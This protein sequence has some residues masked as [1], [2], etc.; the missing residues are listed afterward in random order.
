MPIVYADVLSDG[1]LVTGS[2]S[3][4][5]GHWY[6]PVGAVYYAFYANA[7]ASVTVTCRRLSGPYDPSLWVLQG[8]F[9]DTDIFGGDL[10]SLGFIAFGDDELPPNIPG[11][12]WDPQ[13]SFIAPATGYYTVAVTNFSSNGTPPYDFNLVA[14]G[15]S[16]AAIPEPTTV[17]LTGLGLLALALTRRK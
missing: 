16:S 13:V 3:Q 17:A 12:F 11:P 8:L 14:T 2:I 1:V 15:I 5:N 9:G 6:D 7:G 10:S 4:P